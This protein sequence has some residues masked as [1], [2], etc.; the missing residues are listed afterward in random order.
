[1]ERKII[2]ENIEIE[3]IRSLEV[4]RKNGGYTSIEK[5]LKT[6]TPD[7]IVAEVKTSGLRGRGG[8]GFPTGMKWSFIEKKSGNPRYLICNAY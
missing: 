6:M 7:D 2:L 8:A 4:Y 1:M 5:A 3:G